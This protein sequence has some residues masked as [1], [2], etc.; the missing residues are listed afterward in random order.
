MVKVR[1]DQPLDATGRVDIPAW[2]AHLGREVPLADADEVQRACDYARE[3]V[4]DAMQRYPSWHRL[5]SNFRAGLE[6]A[7]I[8][9]EL[10]LDQ[11][12]LV[13]ALLY[14]CVRKELTTLDNVRQRFGDEVASLI[15]GVL[16]MAAISQLQTPLGSLSQ[17]NQQENLRK[18]LVAM[19]DDVRVALIKI[20]ERTA[21]LRQVRDDS[22]DKCQRVAREVFDIYAPLAHRL[23]IGQIKWE[24]EDL[25]FRYLH[26]DDYKAIAR[27][28]AEKRL[29]R[30]HYIDDVKNTIIDELK[31]HRI[32]R[33]EV[34]GRAKHIYSI[35][36]KMQRKKIEFSEVYDV[37]AVR[38]LVPE[39]GDCY[40]VLGLIHS[41]WHPVPNEF[42]DYIANPKPN[43]YQ[44]L[45]TAVMGPN[46]K[47]L[48][49]QIRTFDMHEDA[50]YGVC[51]HWRYKGH[52]TQSRSSGYE[53]KIAWLRHV[54]DWHEEMG[55]QQLSSDGLRSDIASDRIYVFTPEGHVIDLPQ[56]STPIDFAYRVHTEIGHR[57]RGAKV[58][59]RIVPLTYLLHTG[60]QV[61]I[62]TARQG[63]PSR[64]WINPQLGYARTSRARA[65]IQAWF[66]QQA[67]EQNLE[68][69]KALLEREFRRLDLESLDREKLATAVNYASV[70]DMYAAIGAGDLR[71]GQVLSQAQG[72]FGV[73][74]EQQD[75]DRLLTRG[76]RSEASSQ[77]AITV[78]GVGN[79]KTQMANCCHP[80]PGDAIVGFITHGRGVTVHRQDCPNILQLRVDEPSRI[81]EVEWGASQATVYSVNIEVLAWDRTGILRDVVSV[82]SSEKANVTAV[83]TLSDPDDNT[84][85]LN[86]TLEVAGLEALERIFTHIQQ[87]PNVVDVRRL[88]QGGG[89]SR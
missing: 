48:E 84:A 2:V 81:I 85:K 67:R 71:V 42:D 25:S 16:K 15:D 73:D 80:V 40:T 53:D 39:I 32:D 76:R 75:V 41:R 44:S 9:S 56:V 7:D 72:L 51:A 54:L 88:R 46:H 60:Q 14:R 20:A 62:L 68:E 82:L 55:D 29:D 77:S 61:E 45:H 57:C 64:D 38:V 83:N 33:Y 13:A 11:P 21:M 49:I 66:K 36:R 43:G 5:G 4:L 23:G 37:R 58:D 70:D 30:D 79:L 35:W 3:V 27:Q 17:H 59:G 63:G 26:E 31:A 65:K 12:T 8:L 19:V 87:L 22:R 50:E 6:I 47:A 18:M 86:I 89:S 52:D 28:L 34:N 1:E 24:L 10:Q 69:G 78:L 74:D